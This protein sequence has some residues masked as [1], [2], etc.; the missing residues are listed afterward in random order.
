MKIAF[1]QTWAYSEDSGHKDFPRYDSDQ[2]TMYNAILDAAGQTMEDY[3]NI[4][5]LIPSGTA[6]QNGRQSWLG[7][8]FNSDGY[9]LNTSY[10]CY[11]AACTWFETFAGGETAVGNTY[12]P[13]NVTDA[14]AAVAQHAAH[15]AVES[16]FTVNPMT[17][18]Q[19]AE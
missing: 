8:T 19:S 14:Q 12:I 16:P 17:D 11:T 13:D 15:F 5:I 4:E 3:G 18:F 10:G 2:T 9:H 1:H 6:I 7:D